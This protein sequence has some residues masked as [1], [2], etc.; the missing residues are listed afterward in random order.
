MS[1]ASRMSTARRLARAAAMEASR[2]EA[3]DLAPL[4][5]TFSLRRSVCFRLLRGSMHAVWSTMIL[6]PTILCAS[7]AAACDCWRLAAEIYIDV[8]GFNRDKSLFEVQL[9]DQNEVYV[10][11]YFYQAQEAILTPAPFE[12]SY[13]WWRILLREGEAGLQDPSCSQV[14]I[15][16][17]IQIGVGSLHIESVAV[18]PSIDWGELPE[19]AQE[20]AYS[21]YL[22]LDEGENVW[23]YGGAVPNM[24][25][26]DMLLE[27]YLSQENTWF[28]RPGY[29]FP[30][31]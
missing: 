5:S 28:L 4:P 22:S 29:L 15:P 20:E 19:P 17:L 3:A 6:S 14:S 23:V 21:A 18:W 2:A 1:D 27:D 12:E 10:C 26:S 31:D 24:A 25:M 13:L 16:S 9:L 11:S 8:D 7:L 30:I